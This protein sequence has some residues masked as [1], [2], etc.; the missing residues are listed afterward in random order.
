MVV[1][2]VW[3]NGHQSRGSPNA[4]GN[5]EARKQAQP[6]SIRGV[7]R[8]PAGLPDDNL[9]GAAAAELGMRLMRELYIAIAGVQDR[10]AAAR[11]LRASQ[12][13]NIK[14]QRRAQRAKQ[15]V[16]AA[17]AMA[18]PKPARHPA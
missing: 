7:V 3:V 5:A 9:Q 1:R 16:A 13:T 4:T 12:R 10:R 2:L 11:K 15:Q 17:K 14:A 6:G 18:R 8:L